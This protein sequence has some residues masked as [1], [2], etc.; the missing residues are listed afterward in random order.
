MAAR[1][2]QGTFG[3]DAANSPY[4]SN[5]SGGQANGRVKGIA[6]FQT[7]YGDAKGFGHLANDVANGGSGNP[8]CNIDEGATNRYGGH[9]QIG[10]RDTANAGAG[11]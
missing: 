10:N 11:R 6:Y 9:Q 3:F 2:V 8:Y 4:A 1:Y 5:G 7:S